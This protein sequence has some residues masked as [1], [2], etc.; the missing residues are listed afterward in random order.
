MEK[1]NRFFKNK[2]IYVADSQIHGKGVFTEVDI[3]PGEIIEQAYV[4]HPEN[5]N[6]ESTDKNFQ[7]YF[8]A[9]P[10]LQQNWKNNV[11]KMGFLTLE[12][13]TFA[14][15]VLGFG[16]IYNHSLTPNVLFDVDIDNSMVEF[17]AKRKII[18]GEELLICYN[19]QLKFDEQHRQN[20]N[21]A[22]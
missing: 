8:F 18:A 10:Y 15:C 20:N 11:E 12:Q 13:V 4:I 17:R 16:M 9:W 6:S 1:L 2:N 14:T 19:E 3:L 5:K 7:K 21:I 22:S